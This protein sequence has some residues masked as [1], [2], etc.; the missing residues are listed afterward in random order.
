MFGGQA[1]LLS[2]NLLEPQYGSLGGMVY[3]LSLGIDTN[4]AIKLELV[5]FEGMV[6]REFIFKGKSSSGG[7]VTLSGSSGEL[8]T[9]SALVVGNRGNK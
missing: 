8:D 4:S 5:Y 3:T 7:P 1:G 6:L 2:G 9:M